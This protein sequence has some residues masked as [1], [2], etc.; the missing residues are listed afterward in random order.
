MTCS[1]PRSGRN[2]LLS[3]IMSLSYRQTKVAHRTAAPELRCPTP[4]RTQR[5][6]TGAQAGIEAALQ[7]A[8]NDSAIDRDQVPQH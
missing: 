1:M 5:I 4:R 6:T 7:R 3:T 8:R 2:D